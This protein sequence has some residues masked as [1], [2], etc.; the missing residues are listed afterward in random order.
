MQR[1]EGEWGPEE[2]RAFWKGFGRVSKVFW[3]SLLGT[4]I[5]TIV[6]CAWGW[7]WAIIPTV[8]SGIVLIACTAMFASIWF[9]PDPTL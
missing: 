3:I 7:R 2:W 4:G 1:V 6:V 8:I 5:G 9:W